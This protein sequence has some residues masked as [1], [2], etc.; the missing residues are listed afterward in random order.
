MLHSH[1][2]HDISDYL[3]EKIKDY[4]PGGAGKVGRQAQDNRLF[5]NGVSGF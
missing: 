5:L 3:W 4:L 2:H 1:R